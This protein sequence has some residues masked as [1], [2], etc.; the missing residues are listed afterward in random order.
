MAIRLTRLSLVRLALLWHNDSARAAFIGFV[1]FLIAGPVLASAQSPF[2]TFFQAIDSVQGVGHDAAGN[3][4]V[5]GTVNS[6]PIPGHGVDLV[7][8]PPHSW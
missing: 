1:L 8:A 6:S 7:A 4:Y 2:S 3:I 5:V